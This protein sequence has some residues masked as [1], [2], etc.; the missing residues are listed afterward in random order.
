M[1]DYIVTEIKPDAVMWTGDTT[2]HV[3]KHNSAEEVLENLVKSTNLVSN[4][5]G[6]IP[7]YIAI[8][9]HDTYPFNI[10]KGNAP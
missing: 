2:P 4:A 8:G 6:D 5:L 10:M 3:I 7:L 1:L 9:N